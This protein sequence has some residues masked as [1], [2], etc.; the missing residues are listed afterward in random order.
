MNSIRWVILCAAF[1]LGGCTASQDERI[2]AVKT[3][4]A[5]QDRENVTDPFE[6]IN[7]LMWIVNR[8]VLDRFFLKPLT[9]G[10][11]AITPQVIR[12]GLLN[13]AENV[14]EPASAINNLLQGKPDDSFDSA[15]RFLLNSTVGIFGIFD[16]ATA[17]GIERKQE[18]FNQVLGSYGIGTGP[19]LMVPVFG[20][21]DVR[22]FTGELVDR[23]YWPETVFSDPYAI[24]AG[25]IRLIETRATLL[26][27]EDLLERSLDQY[28]FV[29]DVYFQRAAFE[30]SDGQ[31]G[32]Q[33]EE[34]IEEEADDFAD[35]EALLEGTE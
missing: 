30:L 27:Q 4:Q 20:P 34:E 31:L 14:Q 24:G 6:S 5:K 3:N 7:R 12:T 23:Y 15:T 29:R 1:A 9:Q 28:L 13:A 10:Y 18:D 2:A 19:Y 11:V 8:D 21:S 16:V 35:F 33:T 25:V 32:Q 26:N 17:I 22:N